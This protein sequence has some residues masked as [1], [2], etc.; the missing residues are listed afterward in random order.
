[1]LYK[2]E[3]TGKTYDPKK[4]LRLTN[5]KQLVFYMRKGV[6]I[7]DMYPSK[8]LKNPNEDVLVYL[9]D[10]EQSHE[11]YVEWLERRNMVKR[12]YDL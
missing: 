2:S 5:I 12:E 1:M 8:D 6:D 4:C 10:K 3:M 7:L 11:A 9:V